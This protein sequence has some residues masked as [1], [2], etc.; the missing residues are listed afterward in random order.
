MIITCGDS[1]MAPI[2]GDDDEYSDTHFTQIV[3]NALGRELVVFA[4][5]GMSNGGICL[6]IEAAIKAK[7]DLIII[8]TTFSDRT[9]IAVNSPTNSNRHLPLHSIF[10]YAYDKDSN[11]KLPQDGVPWYQWHKNSKPTLVSESIVNL[12]NFQDYKVN[13]TYMSLPDIDIKVNS[14]KQWFDHLYH[15]VWK[16]KIDS[17]CLAAVVAKLQASGIPYIVAHE[18]VKIDLPIP[19]EHTTSKHFETYKKIPDRDPGYHTTVGAQQKIA[20]LVLDHI[21]KHNLLPNNV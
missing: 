6:Q 12:L 2:Y 11:F 4:R 1:Y 14:V 16:H 21:K 7:P 18:V 15:P 3:A 20:K 10:Y 5:S 8:G 19:D 17:W 9:E 13:P